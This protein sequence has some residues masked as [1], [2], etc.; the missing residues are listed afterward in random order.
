MRNAA[1]HCLEGTVRL[2]D[3]AGAVRFEVEEAEPEIW[4]DANVPIPIPKTWVSGLRAIAR[5]PPPGNVAA[6]DGTIRVCNLHPGEYLL[7]AYST[8]SDTGALGKDIG[9]A[10]KD[11]VKEPVT[12]AD[13]DVSGLVL[14][15]Q[16]QADL[17]GDLVWD[18][19]P[20]EDPI[21]MRLLTEITAAG[22]DLWD[23]TAI[24]TTV[25]HH[26][27]LPLRN[28]DYFAS[29]QA[30]PA[31]V[32]VKDVTYGGRSYLNQVF[33][34]SGT[35]SGLQVILAR[36]GARVSVKAADQDGNA[37]PGATAVIIPAH[38]NSEAAMASAMIMGETDAS[39]TW[40]SPMIA[41]G[42][43]YVIATRMTVN[44]GVETIARLWR[45]RARAEEIE[46]TSGATLQLNRVPAPIE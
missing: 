20:P 15:P 43:Y 37:V 1:S 18:G 28:G 17:E 24:T 26:F 36:D 5:M 14:S 31:G 16:L 8:G 46:V 19:K 2:R 13:L 35:S 30:V 3:G 6:P 4:S 34:A 9:P 25:P 22:A 11:L 7:K 41:P 33:P 27:S 38:A 42:K 39:G 44:H 12:I 29:V 21:S 10:S 32:Y 45:A 40:S 23:V